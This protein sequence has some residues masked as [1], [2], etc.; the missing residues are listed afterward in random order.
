M[1]SV[2]GNEIGR[3]EPPVR[4]HTVDDLEA[5]REPLDRV[6]GCRR[7]QTGSE[8]TFQLEHDLR[9]DLRREHPADWQ[10]RMAGCRVVHGVVVHVRPD[11]RVELEHSPHR[12]VREADLAADGCASAGSSHPGELGLDGIGPGKIEAGIARGRCDRRRTTCVRGRQFLRYEAGIER[13]GHR[14]IISRS[15]PRRVEAPRRPSELRRP[16]AMTAARSASTALP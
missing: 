13:R 16:N 2:G 12:L 7:I 9:L 3:R 14:R 1:E 4:K 15:L 10:R 6:E 11:Q 5:Q 8:R